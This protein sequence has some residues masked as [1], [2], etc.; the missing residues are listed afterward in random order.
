MS[1]LPVQWAQLA[2]RFAALS[3]RERAIIAAAVVF[4]GGLLIFNL[5]IDPLLTKARG[6]SRAEA[7][8]RAELAQQQALAVMLQAQ[9]A[10]PDAANRS[11]LAKAKQELTAVSTR[12]AS[13][14]AGMVPPERM[15]A[16]LEALLSTN[17]NIELR[18]LK[19]LPVSL[20]GAQLALQKS[21]V[22]QGPGTQGARDSNQDKAAAAMP[23]S[24]DGIY[25]HGIE[26]RLAGTYNDL[27]NYLFALE[28]MPQRVMWNSV[29][30]TVERYPRNLLVL[31][32]FTLSL[33]RNWLVV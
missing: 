7:A 2:S 27:L 23:V 10:D 4:G 17:R 13:F 26:I 5:G 32:V 3:R 18:G 14:E 30:L 9:N 1:A 15:Q 29:S 12:L 20:V 11:R 6:A 25:Q 31:R 21:E 19:T 8:A 16:F 33:D 28:S 24:V 22:A